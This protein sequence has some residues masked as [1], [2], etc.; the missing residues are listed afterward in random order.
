MVNYQIRHLLLEDVIEQ[1]RE[2]E[3]CTRDSCNEKSAVTQ[4]CYVK[5]LICRISQ[6]QAYEA[7]ERVFHGKSFFFFEP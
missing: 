6:L 1:K 3:L 7:C 5:G 2:K 4:R